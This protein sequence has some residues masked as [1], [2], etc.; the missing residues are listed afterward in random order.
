M[1]KLFIR[2]V[3]VRRL[4]DNLFVS[5]IGA[6][7]VVRAFLYVTGWPSV[8]WSSFHI[9]HM[10]WG[11]LLMLV[12]L[13]ILLSFL[14]Q[15]IQHLGA[16]IGGVGFGLFIDELGKFITR[17]NDYFFQPTIM[18]IYIIFVGLY[19]IS[20]EL[21]KSIDLNEEERL[22]N[23]LE[24]SKEAVM[25]HFDETERKQMELL[26]AG[27]H[28]VP[29]FKHLQQLLDKTTLL[30]V[31]IWW[32]R[33]RLQDWYFSFAASRFFT[34]S[35]IALLILQGALII[36]SFYGFGLY[37]DLSATE[38]VIVWIGI[39]SAIFAAMYVLGGLVSL[40]RNRFA[41]YQKLY[42]A[43]LISVLL[44]QPFAFYVAT[45]VPLLALVINLGALFTLQYLMDQERRKLGKS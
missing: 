9:A 19:F 17:D 28:H 16:V 29:L 12:A 39:S 33:K 6:I 14:G 8:A 40:R 31:K 27:K 42:R 3:S 18:L 4:L 20:R 1:P 26:L 2:N 15:R 5:A 10:L 23:A 30:P 25:N 41:A 37:E 13:V 24:L 11:G 44:T 45:F 22:V 36:M 35:V 32:P 21:E 7:L 34:P 43:N 38:Q